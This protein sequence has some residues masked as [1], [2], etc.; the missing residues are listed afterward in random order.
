MHPAITYIQERRDAFVEELKAF[1]RIPSIST[2]SEH[3]ADM[4]KA[5]AWVADSMRT[6]G[7]EYV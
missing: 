2:K 7:L 4:Q 1:C 6:I 5:A 3:K